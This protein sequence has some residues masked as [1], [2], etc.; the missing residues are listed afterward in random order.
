MPED[1]DGNEAQEQKVHC[2]DDPGADIYRNL[3][4]HK[5]VQLSGVHALQ[6]DTMIIMYPEGKHGPRK[7]ILLAAGGTIIFRGD[8]WH[9]GAAFKQ[10]NV[11]LHI[12]I[13]TPKRRRQKGYTFS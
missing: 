11:R 7:E 1:R 8:C 3:G 5:H 9:C 12:Y 4:N 6:E 2:D 10:R 13:T